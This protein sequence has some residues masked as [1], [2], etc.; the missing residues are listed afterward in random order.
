MRRGSR[1]SVI[2]GH[3]LF[4]N[5]VRA[6]ALRI[7]FENAP[8]AFIAL[9]PQACIA[10]TEACIRYC[11]ANGGVRFEQPHENPHFAHILLSFQEN[12]L[13]GDLTAQNFD[14]QNL[15]AEQFRFFA[16][17]YLAANF[18]TDFLRLLRRHYMMFERADEN[19]VLQDRIGKGAWSW[20]TEVT[21]IDPALYGTVLVFVMCHGLD[22]NIEAPNL[23]HLVYDFDAM[24]QNV[25]TVPASAYRRLHDL[26]IMEEQLPANDPT[27]WESAVYAFHHVRRRPVLRLNNSR[28][29]CLHKHLLQEKLIGG[30]VHVLTELV[31]SHPPHG[32]PAERKERTNKVRREFGYIFE[33][34]V[35][36]LLDLLFTG[37]DVI[38]RY[39][40]SR[41]SGG[42][43]DA[44][45]V[46][47]RV[48]L[49]FEVVH[50]PWS[51]AERVRGE[52]ADFIP[53]LADN[54]RKAS[55]LCA[56]V[57]LTGRV[58]DLEVAVDTALPIV[59]TSEMTPVNEI[60]ALT[61]QHDLIAATSRELV[62]GHGKVQPVQT[63][64]IAQLENLDRL[65]VPQGGRALAVFLAERSRE[66]FSRLSGHF[67]FG[68]KL[69]STRRLKQFEDEARRSFEEVSRQHFT[70]P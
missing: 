56:Q 25:A 68:N 20:F 11:R 48:A 30:T 47:D 23:D 55:D 36:Q 65:D 54:I 57:T 31:E 9:A 2:W 22:F 4:P 53:H 5:E 50:H 39:G 19:G 66:P 69:G 15:T 16:K 62:L 13:R 21:G 27:D 24:L 1:R 61:W 44:L 17:N 28:Y 63:L 3:Y 35:R 41:S 49:A 46:V 33:D 10:M 70:H 42:E 45:V 14:R 60:T 34:Y 29:I 43:S 40:L 7:Y 12:L 37:S 67:A 18:E 52:S 32:W 58:D 51:L 6:R 8:Q 59:V 26:A 64:S 38:R